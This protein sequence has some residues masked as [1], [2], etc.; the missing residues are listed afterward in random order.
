[1]GLLQAAERLRELRAHRGRR[2]VTSGDMVAD[3]ST[4]QGRRAAADGVLASVRRGLDGAVLAARLGPGSG[5]DRN[6]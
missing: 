2:D 6:R 1:M 5:A 3:P 4:P